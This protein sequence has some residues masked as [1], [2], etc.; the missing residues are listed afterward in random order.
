MQAEKFRSK[1]Q[2][3]ETFRSTEQLCRYTFY[4]GRIRAI[5]LE[6]SDAKDALLQAARKVRGSCLISKL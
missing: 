1:A 2:R 6:Y 3:S 5:R 4:L